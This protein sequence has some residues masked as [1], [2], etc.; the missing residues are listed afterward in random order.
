MVCSMFPTIRAWSRK[1]ATGP[2]NMLAS[3]PRV[4]YSSASLESLSDGIFVRL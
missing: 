4:A 3:G 1:R 2:L